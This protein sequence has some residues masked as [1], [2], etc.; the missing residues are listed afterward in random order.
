[1]KLDSSDM[2]DYVVEV[3]SRV[4]HDW[5]DALGCFEKKTSSQSSSLRRGMGGGAVIV[6]SGFSDSFVVLKLIP[7]S[8]DAQYI[9]GLIKIN[10]SITSI[11]TLE[12]HTLNDGFARVGNHPD[13]TFVIDF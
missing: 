8:L 9:S 12:T 1:M 11:S 2:A 5:D 7:D 3:N 4:I 6:S 13:G 10:I